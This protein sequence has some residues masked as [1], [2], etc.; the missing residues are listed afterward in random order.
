M[1]PTYCRPGFVIVWCS[2]RPLHLHPKKEI[3]VPP[4]LLGFPNTAAPHV[5]D[6]GPP[7]TKYLLSCDRFHLLWFC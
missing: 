5:F 1:S 6:I 7:G 2:A 4:Y 3:G